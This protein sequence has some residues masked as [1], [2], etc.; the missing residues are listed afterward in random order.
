MES[1]AY[2]GAT[3]LIVALCRFPLPFLSANAA[4]G[5]VA[6]MPL[7]DTHEEV[8]PQTTSLPGLRFDISPDGRFIVFDRVTHSE[9]DII[10]LRSPQ[11]TL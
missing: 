7:T 8:V 2:I 4:I 6:P 5:N 11:R 3:F 10:D 1:S 9:S